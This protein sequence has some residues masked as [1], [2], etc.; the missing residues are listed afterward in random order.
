M[1]RKKNGTKETDRCNITDIKVNKPD[2]RRHR[3]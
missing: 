3:N 1:K 2:R